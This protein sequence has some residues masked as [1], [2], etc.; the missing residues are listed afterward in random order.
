MQIYNILYFM[1]FFRSRSRS[2]SFFSGAGGIFPELNFFSGAGAGG[3]FPELE[4]TGAGAPLF[5]TQKNNI[6]N[7]IYLRI[8]RITK[9]IEKKEIKLWVDVI[10][11]RTD[12][13]KR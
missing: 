10:F 13:I 12:V 11:R 3:I 6:N 9:N 8:I 7:N 1:L 2:R 5:T 4:L